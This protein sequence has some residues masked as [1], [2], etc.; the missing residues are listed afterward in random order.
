MMT[1]S[2]LSVIYKNVDDLKPN[3]R[4]ARTHS[5][6]QI[7]KI[8]KSIKQFGFAN[9]VLIDNENTIIA[10][11]GRFE[12]AKLLDLKEVPAILLGDL[13]KEQ[14]R[15]YMLADNKLAEESGWDKDVLRLEFQ[16][17]MDLG[18]DFDLTLTG[19]EIP[20][21]DFIISDEKPEQR[22]KADIMP[23]DEEIKAV[24][25]FGDLWKLGE[26]Y[27]YCGNAL[28]D[29]SYKIL[30]GQ[31]KAKMIF[32]DP[33][34]NVK[35]NGHVCGKGKIK[36]SEFL[37]ASGEMKTE[38]FAKFLD[39]IF[40]NLKIFS[41]NGSIHFIFMDWRH[42]KEVLD[43]GLKN[44][45]SYINL[46]VWNK[47]QGGMGSLYRSQHELV[48]V[49]KNGT[50]SHINNIELGKHGRFR[51]NVW[52]Y[53]GIS[54]TNPHSLQD[55]KYHPTCKPIAL[56][57]D[58]I[59]D[60]SNIGD[61][62]LDPFAGSGTTLLAAERTGRKACVME[63]DPHYCDVIIHRYEKLFSK[64]AVKLNCRKEKNNDRI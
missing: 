49:F 9:P 45:D 60:C 35:I 31:A 36:H 2:N 57:M 48:F 5:Q 62:I 54:V 29:E 58:A 4:N 27:L 13:S 44:Y 20:E 50:E 53:K 41:T 38:E 61:I 7:K 8:A 42:A 3:S 1:K 52:E 15:A 14:V 43:A 46:C 63:L 11:H 16:E 47:L 23:E 12:A 26:H 25:N 18:Y 30:L 34:Y 56:V 24:V 37:M 40:A 51:T 22:D 17:L 21:I 6:K 10:G 32:T 39:N 59:R 64:K 19:F 33:P 28:Y 55:L